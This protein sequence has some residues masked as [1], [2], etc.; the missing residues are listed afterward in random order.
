MFS[1]AGQP[2]LVIPYLAFLFVTT[3][4]YLWATAPKVATSP[5]N[6]L[7]SEPAASFVW[8]SAT[9]IWA[10]ARGTLRQ[11][12]V[13]ALP[14]FFVITLVASLLDWLGV[15]GWASRLLTPMMALFNLPAEAALPVVL[16]S[17][18]KDGILLFTTAG[19]DGQGL[20]TPMTPVQILTG[21]YLAGVLL[22][23]LVTAWTIQREQGARFALGLLGRQAV[24]AILFSAALA[25]AGRLVA[26]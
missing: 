11:F 21:V 7:V 6:I 14:V 13:T 24:A 9:S 25:W 23:C 15:V 5:L 8:P 1:A 10:E 2:S 16:A 3:V 17:I 22:P 12:F 19:V 20:V 18:R 4:I 26:S